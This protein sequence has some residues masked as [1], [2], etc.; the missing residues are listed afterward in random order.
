MLNLTKPEYVMPFHGDFK[1]LRLHGDLAESVGIE[2]AKVFRGRNGLPL[3]ITDTGA[4]FGEDIDSGMIFVDG[5]DIGDPDDAALRDRRHL[6]DDGVVIVVATI[7]AKDGSKVAEPE[8]LFRGV[9]FIE[10][11]DGLVEELREIVAETLEEAAEDGVRSAAVIQ[12]DLHED[13]AGFVHE[14]LKRRPLVM[15]VV[16]EV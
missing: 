7:S 9:P 5:L 6:S 16:V 3:E 10:E 12:E 15:P 13:I 8:I 14:Q 4:S 11:E 1:R 2:P